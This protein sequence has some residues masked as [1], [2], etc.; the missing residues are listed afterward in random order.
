MSPV[1][2][3][4]DSSDY[5][6]LG[7]VRANPG[8]ARQHAIQSAGGQLGSA[9]YASPNDVRA[10]G[11]P[12][13]RIAGTRRRVRPTPPMPVVSTARARR[14]PVRRR[15]GRPRPRRPGRTPGPER[16]AGQRG[17][18]DIENLGVERG[19]RTLRWTGRCSTPW[20]APRRASS[21]TSRDGRRAVPATT[22]ASPHSAGSGP[23]WMPSTA[24]EDPLPPPLRRPAPG[25]GSPARR[26]RPAPGGRGDDCPRSR[27]SPALPDWGVSQNNAPASQ[28]GCPPSPDP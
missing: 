16:P 24:S 28:R 6:S 23:P 19:H 2:A 4:P 1:V 7:Y 27:A 20:P 18:A 8:V 25:V 3:D 21:G 15:A 5:A 11:S 14:L 12:P 17:S 9:G 22:P 13:P 10:K 26:E